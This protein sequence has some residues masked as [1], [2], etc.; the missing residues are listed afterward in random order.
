[1]S[2]HLHL[3]VLNSTI[4]TRIDVKHRYPLVHY[5]LWQTNT[6]RSTK[7]HIFNKR[8]VVMFTFRIQKCEYAASDLW[9]FI[10]CVHTHRF[11][12]QWGINW[13]LKSNHLTESCHSWPILLHLE[14]RRVRSYCILDIFLLH[15]RQ[16]SIHFIKVPKPMKCSQIY[17]LARNQWDG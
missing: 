12:V 11:S 15:L 16:F 13:L 1:M 2:F 10:I 5:G 6:S 4:S 7:S 14:G 17:P 8:H 3:V 9:I